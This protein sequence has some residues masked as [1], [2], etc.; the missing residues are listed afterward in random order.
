M[1]LLA[2]NLDQPKNFADAPLLAAEGLE[3][4]IVLSELLYASC[5]R[6][7]YVVIS[8]NGNLTRSDA[9][10]VLRLTMDEVLEANLLSI[11]LS[12]Q[13]EGIAACFAVVCTAHVV[14]P[15]IR[16][17]EGWEPERLIIMSF[18]YFPL[19]YSKHTNSSP[20][21]HSELHYPVRYILDSVAPR[22]LTNTWIL[23]VGLALL[24][25]ALATLWYLR[26][27]GGYK[28]ATIRLAKSMLSRWERLRHGKLYDVVEGE[29]LKAL[30]NSNQATELVETLNVDPKE[31]WDRIFEQIY[32]A[33]EY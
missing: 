13:E 22:Y 32:T 31:A 24:C 28:I 23:K 7:C 25:I 18:V 26:P 30:P 19:R 8:L 17:V 21:G 20:L 33:D 6:E 10:N 15:R 27:Q 12:R 3:A 1:T 5:P 9:S 16:C 11:T 4:G 29:I 14:S 2:I